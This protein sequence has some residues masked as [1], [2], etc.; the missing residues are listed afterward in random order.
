MIQW[1][2]KKQLHFLHLFVHC[3]FVYLFFPLA[4][5]CKWDTD[6][7]KA[8]CEQNAINSNNHLHKKTGYLGSD[9]CFARNRSSMHNWSWLLFFP[10]IGL[11]SAVLIL[12]VLTRFF[13][14]NR[15]Y[16]VF[17]SSTFLLHAARVGLNRILFV[18]GCS[19]W[20][21][22]DN[23]GIWWII[24][25]PITASLLVRRELWNGCYLFN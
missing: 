9:D 13:F 16:D 11:P 1:F 3:L 12:W 19:C 7:S 24:K 5:R 10:I 25:G 17:Y 4:Q 23:V 2:K 18:S 14:D 6:K 22:T 21:D 15:G 20:D 8:Q